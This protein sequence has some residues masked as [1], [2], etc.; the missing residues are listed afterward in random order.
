MRTRFCSVVIVL[1]I[2]AMAPLP[3]YCSVPDLNGQN[4]LGTTFG[5]MKN[6]LVPSYDIA[7][8]SLV[9][10]ELLGLIHDRD[11]REVEWTALHETNR[12]EPARMILAHDDRDEGDDEEADEGDGGD[13]E[14]EGGEEGGWDRTWDAP[15]LG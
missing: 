12:V 5:G 4:G 9:N 14:E 3:G 1:L 15:K 8:V 13:E 11:L 7:G 10:S 6:P 2:G